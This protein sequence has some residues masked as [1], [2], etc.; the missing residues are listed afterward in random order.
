HAVLGAE[1]NRFDGTIGQIAADEVLIIFNDPLPCAEP[2]LWALRMV[3]AARDGLMTPRNQWARR[4]HELGFG[5][6]IDFGYAALG[7]MGFAERLDYG[8]IGAVTKAAIGL[9]DLAVDQHVLVTRRVYAA[10]E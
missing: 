5:V 2:A 10:V 1:V 8:A 3:L 7:P 6:G 4:G 9:A